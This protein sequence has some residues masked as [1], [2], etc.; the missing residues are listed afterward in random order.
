MFNVVRRQGQNNPR[1]QSFLTEWSPFQVME[2]MLNPDSFTNAVSARTEQTF[3]PR[4]DVKETKD[5]FFFQADLPGLK[6][7]DVTI[8]LTG[9][10]LSITGKR[11]A[12]EKKEGENYYMLERK[13]GSFS[14]V[15]TLPETADLDKIKAEMKEGVLFLSLPKR[16]ESQPRRISISK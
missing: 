12:E 5:G 3:A 6:E 2:A 1:S 11:D 4:F 8:S 10:R 16:A 14:R 9:N 7:E 15:F 13:H